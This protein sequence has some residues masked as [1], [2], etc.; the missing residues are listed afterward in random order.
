M[1][2]L[3]VYVT[4][5]ILAIYNYTKMLSAQSTVEK[6]IILCLQLLLIDGDSSYMNFCFAA[7]SNPIARSPL[8]ITLSSYALLITVA[9]IL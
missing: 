8:S 2:S 9:T 3:F 6:S 7:M 5:C 1:K 4:M